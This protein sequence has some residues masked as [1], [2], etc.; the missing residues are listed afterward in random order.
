[1]PGSSLGPLLLFPEFFFLSIYYYYYIIACSVYCYTGT[2]SFLIT[3]YLG[4][5]EVYLECFGGGI[6]DV[7]VI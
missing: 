3:S 5:L 6:V 2:S 4:V 1:M 7:R